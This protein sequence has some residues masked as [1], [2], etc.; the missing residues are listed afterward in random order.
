MT[1]GSIYLAGLMFSSIM[2]IGASAIKSVYRKTKILLLL[3]ADA[4]FIASHLFYFSYRPSNNGIAILTFIMI[5]AL[6]LW[7]IFNKEDNSK[8]TIIAGSNMPP[9][10]RED[11]FHH[12]EE[13]KTTSNSG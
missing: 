2:L 11:L 12:T 3:L 5:N 8:Q 6:I 13:E 10:W 7:K 4:G 1:Q 9:N